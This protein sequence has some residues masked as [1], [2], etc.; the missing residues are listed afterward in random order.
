MRSL[1]N[2]L[3]DPGLHLLVIAVILAS[4]AAGGS[5]SS[6]AAGEDPLPYCQSCHSHFLPGHPCGCQA[7]GRLARAL[8]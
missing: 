3:G 5:W 1:L 6:G 2:G 4:L 7:A 8:P